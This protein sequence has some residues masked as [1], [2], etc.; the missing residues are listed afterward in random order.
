MRLKRRHH[1]VLNVS[2]IQTDCC[3]RLHTRHVAGQAGAYPGFCSMKRRGVF[4][5]PL[6]GMLLHHSFKFAG[7]HSC[8]WVER[9]TVRV[10]CLAQEHNAISQAR[11][12]TRT[13]QSG[14]EPLTI[15]GHE[16]TAPPNNYCCEVKPWSQTGSSG[17]SLS[18]FP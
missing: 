15:T 9:G 18:R 5:S 6:D 17:R 8:P 14:A 10:K 3:D 1:S 16:A 7:T 2:K 11:A 12:R 13:A 4:Y